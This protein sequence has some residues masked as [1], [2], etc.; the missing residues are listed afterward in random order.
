M[1]LCLS[2]GIARGKLD[3]AHR[4]LA[5]EDMSLMSSVAPALEVNLLALRSTV[6]HTTIP[7]C[8]KYG[9]DTSNTSRGALHGHNNIVGPTRL[10]GQGTRQTFL[11]S[12]DCCSLSALHP[13]YKLASSLAAAK[14]AK[15]HVTGAWCTLY[16]VIVHSLLLRCTLYRSVRQGPDLRNSYLVN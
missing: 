5:T 1:T 15:G 6:L 11:C 13:G 12:Q 9:R 16:K 2:S 14:L 7:N 3:R 10:G 4:S 8:V